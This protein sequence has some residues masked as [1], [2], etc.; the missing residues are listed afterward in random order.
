MPTSG[1][2]CRLPASVY[3]RYWFLLPVHLPHL[4]FRHFAAVRAYRYCRMPVLARRRAR[5]VREQFSY[6]WLTCAVPPATRTLTACHTPVHFYHRHT[7]HHARGSLYAVP[8]GSRCVLPAGSLHTAT[9]ARRA[10]RFCR[11]TYSGSAC[12]HARQPPQRRAATYAVLFFCLALPPRFGALARQ[13]M[14]PPHAA[15]AVLDNACAAC[16]TF[17]YATAAVRG[18]SAAACCACCT[19]YA[20]GSR[21]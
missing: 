19:G 10:Q 11:L 16:P 4:A 15:F 9:R 12:R 13:H 3:R 2:R 7:C 20:Y 8:A 1:S 5:L 14:L 18:S 17:S 6:A 21:C